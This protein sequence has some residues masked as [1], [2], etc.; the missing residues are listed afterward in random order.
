MM[1]QTHGW[2]DGRAEGCGSG[3]RSAVTVVV[4]LVIVIA[5]LVKK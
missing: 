3:R 1:N 5:K 2:M 4:L